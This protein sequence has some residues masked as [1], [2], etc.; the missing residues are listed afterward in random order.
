MTSEPVSRPIVPSPREG[1]RRKFSE[2]DK[3]QIVDEASQ[4]GANLSAV[5]R[6]YGIAVRV[7]FRW[8]QELAPPVFVSVQVTDAAA[9]S[10]AAPAIEGGLS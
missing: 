2:A 4:P 8:K 6:Q 9:S 10:G 3:R 1:H 5:A 7:L